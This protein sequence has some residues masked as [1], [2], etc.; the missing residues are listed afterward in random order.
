MDPSRIR[1]T[2]PLAPHVEDLWSD[3]LAQ[4]Y[5]P[6]SSANVARLMADLSRWLERKRLAPGQLNEE[7]VERF[8]RHRKRAGYTCWRS[9]RG[10]EPVL[11]CLRRLGVVPQLEVAE[12]IQGP[13]DEL[14]RPYDE[15][16]LHERG[17]TQ[18]TAD[19]Y[20]R[21]V[22]EFLTGHFGSRAIDV[23]SLTATDVC[24]FVLRVS[25]TASVSYTKYKVSALRS[26]LRYLYVRGKLAVDLAA[27]VPTAAGWRLTSLPKALTPEEVSRLLRSC[28]RRTHVGRRSYAAMLTMV[29]LGLR[30]G[31]VAALELDDVH[32]TRGEIVIHG[33]GGQ[34]DRLPLP[35]DVGTA[36]ASY[37]RRSRP[38]VDSRKVFLRVRAP[39]GALSSSG[40]KAIVTEAG[41]RAGFVPL[42]AHRLRHTAA[43]A[44]LRE[45]AS[46]SHIAQVLRHRH[47]DTTAIYA[48]VDRNSL[49]TLVQPWP[50]GAA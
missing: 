42:G 49:R 11:A 26:F 41:R 16:L 7:Q 15:Y 32:W 28:D 20:E 22:R 31:E 47:L 9:K 29:R 25:R 44:M 50:G 43:T 27:S 1:I 46:L 33:K 5:T 4:G 39:Q 10:L 30:A 3:L 6:L 34:A 38:R 35:H 18:A 24:D 45:G 14:L 13:L 40:V 2:G 48:K 8:V 21:V 17:V 36:L 19:F 23:G 37:V 12:V